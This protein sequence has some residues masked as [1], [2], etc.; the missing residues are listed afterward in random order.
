MKYL[1]DYQEAKQTKLFNQTGAFFAFSTDQ[2]NE[3]KQPDTKYVNCKYGLMCPK[4]QVKILLDGLTKAHQEAIKEDIADNGIN[5][6][7]KR[8]L[9]N[10]ECFYS[11][12]ISDAVS[13]LKA[14]DV[15]E[16]QVQDMYR[17]E[18]KNADL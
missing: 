14:Y 11:G 13:T 9:Y 3:T 16:D 6:I 7:I 8:E 2:F 17:K 1:S 18:Y 15:T 5:A 12:D 4:G 10:Y